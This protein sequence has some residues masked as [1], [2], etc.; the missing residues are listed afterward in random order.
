MPTTRI[1][2]G[3]VRHPHVVAWVVA[4]FP[5]T[6]VALSRLDSETKTAF[7]VIIGSFALL[8]SLW[9]AIDRWQWN[10]VDEVRDAGDFLVIIDRGKE[11][12]VPLSD[13]T[14]ITWLDRTAWTYLA[15]PRITLQ[16]A[17]PGK[18]GRT[19]IFIPRDH[20]TE[21]VAKGLQARVRNRRQVEARRQPSAGAPQ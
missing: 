10:I 9:I 21:A 19:I 11:E 8:S 14:S 15:V 17:H 20:E 2:R 12:A 1:S 3:R 18:L 4:A 6:L 16:F 5:F 13:I 7:F